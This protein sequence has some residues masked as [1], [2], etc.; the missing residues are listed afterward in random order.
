MKK[1]LL[2]DCDG[3]LVDSERICNAALAHMLKPLGVDLPPDEM[4]KKFR[5]EKLLNILNTLSSEFKVELPEGFVE[6]YRKHLTTLLKSN[7]KPI[8]GIEQALKSINLPMAIVSNAPKSK[9]ELAIKVCG[10]AEFFGS[11]IFSAYDIDVWKPDPQLYLHASQ[12]LG[13]PPRD[14]IVIEDGLPGVEAGVR[15][16][17]TTLFFNRHGDTNIFEQDGVIEFKSMKQLQSL[18]QKI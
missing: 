6:D 5:G 7:L 18:I 15:A 12:K 13:I 10:I 14:C 16:G 9:V 17:M 8:E 11:H 2:F 3:T 1:Q 4:V